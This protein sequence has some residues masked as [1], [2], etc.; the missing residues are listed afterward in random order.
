MIQLGEIIYIKTSELGVN[1]K[2]GDR[3]IVY[4]IYNPEDIPK[5]DV[6]GVDY[7]DRTFGVFQFTPADQFATYIPV[8]RLEVKPK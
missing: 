8:E 7:G 2:V 4:G 3:Y 1:L 5:E 6:E